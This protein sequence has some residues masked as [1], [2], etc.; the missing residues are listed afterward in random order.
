[1]GEN[2]AT[3]WAIGRA[4]RGQVACN[5]RQ[6]MPELAASLL[7]NLLFILAGL[8]QG[9]GGLPKPLPSTVTPAPRK[10]GRSR[11]GSASFDFVLILGV[12]L[13]LVTLIMWVGPR[14]MRL[15]Y[16]I[17]CALISWPFM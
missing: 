7:E 3:G 1:M 16:Q 14:I 17:A 2:V 8:G 5:K 10:R 12:V 4:A 9:G 11:A 13:P 15:A 6:N